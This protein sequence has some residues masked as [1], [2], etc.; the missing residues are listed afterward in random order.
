MIK[1]N[2]GGIL[3]VGNNSIKIQNLEEN[4]LLYIFFYNIS[5]GNIKN[6]IKWSKRFYNLN[7]TMKWHYIHIFSKHLL[8]QSMGWMALSYGTYIDFQH[9]I[10]LGSYIYSSGNY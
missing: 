2:Q 7:T 9:F 8:V 3:N 1:K 6:Y 10:L 5:K 4:V